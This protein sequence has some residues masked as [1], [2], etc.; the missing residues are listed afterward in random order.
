[1]IIEWPL[2]GHFHDVVINV[3]TSRTN[4]REME[5]KDDDDKPRLKNV[6]YW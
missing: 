4:V 2:N 1:M 6:F 5:D 3:L